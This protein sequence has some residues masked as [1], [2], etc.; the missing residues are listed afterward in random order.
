CTA[1][2]D[3][4]GYGGSRPR[5]DDL[6]E[7]LDSDSDHVAVLF[8]RL[9]R[10]IDLNYAAGVGNA[11]IGHRDEIDFQIVIGNFGFDGIT[12]AVQ[13]TDAALGHEQL[14]LVIGA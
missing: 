3:S 1:A 5:S 12:G 6:L 7:R 9:G 2:V 4:G 8:V 14:K 13:V 10:R 11:R